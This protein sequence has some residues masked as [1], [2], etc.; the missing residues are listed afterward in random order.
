MTQITQSRKGTGPNYEER[1]ENDSLCVTRCPFLHH[2]CNR[3]NLR[4]LCR[5]DTVLRETYT[6]SL[7]LNVRK[8]AFHDLVCALLL[9][10]GFLT[11]N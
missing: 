2:L 7:A 11:E 6:L 3:R 1:T 10:I 8:S 5:L 9:S 4:I